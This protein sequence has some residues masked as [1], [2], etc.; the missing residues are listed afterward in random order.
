MAVVAMVDPEM[1]E[2]IVPA[3][4]ATTASRAGMRRIRRSMPSMTLSATPVWNRT[5]PIRTN[6]GMG[7]SEKLV[8]EA[9]PLRTNWPRPG[10]PPRNS[11]APARLMT[12]KEKATGR[13]RKSSAVEPP[14]S[15]SEACCQV[16]EVS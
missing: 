7:V 3:T 10:S 5:S 1:A 13:P 12:R 4:T 16:I 14:N 9:E 11:S 2:K 6:S 15:S 8:M